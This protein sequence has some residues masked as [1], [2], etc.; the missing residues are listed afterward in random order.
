M[1]CSIISTLWGRGDPTACWLKK[2]VFVFTFM[3]VCSPSRIRQQREDDR[4]RKGW[5]SKYLAQIKKKKDA[6]HISH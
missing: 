6:L 1:S 2:D 5:I 4:Q 3:V